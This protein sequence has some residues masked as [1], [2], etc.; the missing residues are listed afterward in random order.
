MLRKLKK[1]FLIIHREM[2]STTKLMSP[3]E[4]TCE[5]YQLLSPDRHYAKCGYKRR[6]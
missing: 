1:I 4:W 2:K 3:N 5:G 6:R